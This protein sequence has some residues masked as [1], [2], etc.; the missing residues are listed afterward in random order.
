MSVNCIRC[1]KNPRTGFDLLCD[2]C[3]QIPPAGSEL[4]VLNEPPKHFLFRAVDKGELIGHVQELRCAFSAGARLVPVLDQPGF[5]TETHW[6]G[7]NGIYRLC[8]R[9]GD[10]LEIPK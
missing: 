5:Y 10:P 3:R 8:D 1:V 6:G 2:V 9:N 7:G 4:F